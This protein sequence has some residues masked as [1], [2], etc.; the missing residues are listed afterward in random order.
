MYTNY[1]FHELHGLAWIE[2]KFISKNWSAKEKGRL[3]FFYG[4]FQYTR[5]FMPRII[6]ISMDKSGIYFK[7][8]ISKRKRRILFP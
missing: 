4:Q 5:I 1:L 7:E 3:D 8:L 6:W 2:A